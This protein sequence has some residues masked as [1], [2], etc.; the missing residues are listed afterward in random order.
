MM[1]VQGGDAQPACCCR[2]MVQETRR[3]QLVVNHQVGAGQALDGADGDQARMAGPGPNQGH[4]VQALWA[5][6]DS[7]IGFAGHAVFLGPAGKSVRPAEIFLY[8][9]AI[10]LL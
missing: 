7:W 9:G 3:H 5:V 10:R 6:P 4:G 2:G 1:I 8:A